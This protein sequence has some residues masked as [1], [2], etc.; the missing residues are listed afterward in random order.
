MA[1][2]EA[3]EEDS[4]S[5]FED[6]DGFEDEGFIHE[7]ALD[8]AHSITSPSLPSPSFPDSHRIPQIQ[9]IIT[10]YEKSPKS[11]SSVQLS[12]TSPTIP[13]SNDAS[14]SL[15]RFADALLAANNDNDGPPDEDSLLLVMMNELAHRTRNPPMQLFLVQCRRGMELGIVNRIRDDIR[16][17]GVDRS[18][19]DDAFRSQHSGHIY[20][21]AQNM[22]PQNTSLAAYLHLIDG[23][24]YS[25]PPQVSYSN[26][27][28]SSRVSTREDSSSE[29][30]VLSNLVPLWESHKLAMPKHRF[31]PFADSDFSTFLTHPHS[32]VSVGKWMKAK[33]GLYKGDVGLVVD[34]DS[35]RRSCSM[36]FIPRL[37]VRKETGQKRRRSH[38]PPP[39][40][41]RAEPVFTIM[42]EEKVPPPVAVCPELDCATPMSCKHVIAEERAWR[43]M[44]HKFQGQLALVDLPCADV[45]QANVIPEQIGS[46]FKRSGHPMLGP[47]SHNAMPPSSDW[48]FYPDEPVYLVDLF[49]NETLFITQFGVASGT[50]ALVESSSSGF[51]D[52]VV[53]HD[54]P[55]IR[56]TIRISNKYLRKIIA[57]GDTVEILASSKLLR[58]P[59]VAGEENDRV[60]VVAWERLSLRGQVGSVIGVGHTGSFAQVVGPFGALNVH[61]NSL[62]CL[63]S[64]SSSVSKPTLNLTLPHDTIVT[65]MYRSSLNLIATRETSETPSPSW[66]KRSHPWKGIEVVILGKH[67]RKGYRAVVKDVKEEASLKSGIG[68]HLQYTISN[69]DGVVQEWVDYDLI[70]R[71]EYMPSTSTNSDPT[72]LE[73]GSISALGLMFDENLNNRMSSQPQTY[74]QALTLSTSMS[75]SP[76]NPPLSQDNILES[77]QSLSLETMPYEER[78]QAALADIEC[79][80]ASG[81]LLSIRAAANKYEVARSTT[82]QDR[83][84]GRL[85]RVDAHAHQQKLTPAQEDILV[86][87]VKEQGRRGVPLSHSAIANHASDIA[88]IEIGK[89]W[90]HNFRKRHQDLRTS[91]TSSL[92]ECR[93][94]ALT[95]QAVAGFYDLLYSIVNKPG[96]DPIPPENIYNADEKGVQVGVGEKSKV[97]IDRDQKLVQSM[98][99][100]NKDL[101][102]IIECVAAD[103]TF[104]PPFIIFEGVRNLVLQLNRVYIHI[105]KTNF[106]NHY[107]TARSEAFKESTI[108]SAFRKTGIHPFNRTAIPESAFAPAKNFTTQSSQPVPAQLPTILV[109]VDSTDSLDNEPGTRTRQGP[110]CSRFVP[111]LSSE[112]IASSSSLTETSS[113]TPSS[114][115]ATS[116]TSIPSTTIQ[117][118]IA[119][120]PPKQRPTAEELYEENKVLRSLA[121]GAG[122]LLEAN[123]AQMKLM[124][125]ENQK[126]RFKAFGKKKQRVAL[127]TGT[128]RHLTSDEMVNMLAKEDFKKS[129]TA[130]LKQVRPRFKAIRKQL[131]DAEKALKIARKKAESQAKKAAKAA[132][133]EAAKAN[134]TRGRGRGHSRGRG[135]GRGRGRGRGKGSARS[136]PSP[137]RDKGKGRAVEPLSSSGESFDSLTSGSDTESSHGQGEQRDDDIGDETEDTPLPTEPSKPRPKP[138]PILRPLSPQNTS[139]P[140]HNTPLVLPSTSSHATSVAPPSGSSLYSMSTAFEVPGSEG[141]IEVKDIIGHRWKGKGLSFYVLWGDG[142]QTWEKLSGVNE[143]AALD[144]YLAFHKIDDPSQL[145][146]QQ[147]F[148]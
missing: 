73:K 35:R 5:E 77:F 49:S 91:W 15:Q 122:H 95:P 130:V 96:E 13:P 100:G 117:Y 42:R 31:I 87:W 109:P 69:L 18:V 98:A 40:P 36:L 27:Q 29:T 8:T 107:A 115:T 93:A 45:E 75:P 3:E 145:S 101:I 82:L 4:G 12:S 106:L 41:L 60:P 121:V 56:Q 65:E 80:A 118:R 112:S 138:R 128:A 103:G 63:P 47:I 6:E 105:D 90:I 137:G 38:R 97:L 123:Y 114:S 139:P 59:R 57:V 110:I 11:Q 79:S 64:G 134:S 22:L 136:A 37:L 32:D 71:T 102:T 28:T 124:E 33:R 20:L 70:R 17:D 58:T 104:L 81:A 85:N 9:E 30:S 44:G 86:Q 84:Y 142:D 52:I 23:F 140:H 89:N 66:T 129:M 141:E 68:I 21:C 111:L 43:W 50:V 144:E 120:P 83:H 61:V 10:R 146:K 51:C 108:I 67:I 1:S 127:N 24:I 16:S 143:W 125:A 2:L 88:G 148:R 39:T 78:I 131:A 92:E 7:G 113:A 26:I 19:I 54:D 135:Q 94:R 46:Y 99:H 119:L 25:S 126:L 62:H 14:S 76:N 132:Q 72:G 53:L 116:S 74:N 133:K 48:L 55:P 147:F 34:L